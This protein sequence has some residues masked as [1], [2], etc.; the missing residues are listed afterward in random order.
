[1]IS[2]APVIGKM[3][4]RG[5]VPLALVGMQDSL[6]IYDILDLGVVLYFMCVL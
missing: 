1:M 6:P 2:T 4:P 5:A 3:G